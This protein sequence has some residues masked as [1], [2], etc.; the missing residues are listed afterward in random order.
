[1]THLLGVVGTVVGGPFLFKKMSFS[2]CVKMVV[3]T[4]V[5]TVVGWTFSFKKM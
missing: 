3:D 2:F 5:G 4:V 1:M